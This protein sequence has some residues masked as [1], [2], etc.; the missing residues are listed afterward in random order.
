LI[1]AAPV[2]ATPIDVTAATRQV[3]VGS[4]E[5]NFPGPN[6]PSV[7]LG[8]FSDSVTHSFVGTDGTTLNLEACQR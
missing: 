7:V 5:S 3:Q 6:S 4:A 2:T 8:S 1:G